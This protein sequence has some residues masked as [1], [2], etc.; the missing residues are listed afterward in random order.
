MI[1]NSVRPM[2]S[3]TENEE[4]ARLRAALEDAEQ[5]LRV[6][7]QGTLET[8]RR[9]TER[10]FFA[11]F[12]ESPEPMALTR[13][14]DGLI[15]DVNQEW[16]LLTRFSRDEVI[17]R[18]T[19]EIN[20]WPTPADRDAAMAPLIAKGRLR[21]HE[22]TMVMKGGAHRLTRMNSS[23]IN[24]MGEPHVLTHVKDITAE[25]MA[26][27][28][29]RSGELALAQA[30]EKLNEQLRLY[31][32]TENLAHVGHGMATTDGKTI[33]WSN[34]LHAI[35][36]T[37][38]GN[39]LTREQ[40]LNSI[41]EEDFERYLQARRKMDGTTVEFRL[42]H[43]DGSLRWM[44]SR[45]HRQLNS[46]GE[47]VEFDLVQDITAERAVM[48]ALQ[49]KLDFIEKITSRIPDVV[50]Q[51][52]LG[53]DGRFW[54]PFI[55]EGL[56]K[57]FRVAPEDARRDPNLLFAAIHPDDAPEVLALM[58]R[59]Y[60]PGGIWTHEYRVR[61]DDGSVRWVQGHASTYSE[62]DGTLVSY[63]S[64]TDINNLKEAEVRA[65]DS[66]AR[67]RS[68]TDLSSDW[69]WELDDQFRFTRIDGFR[70]NKSVISLHESLGKTRWEIGGLNLSDEDWR[71]HRRTL[72]AHQRFQDFEI[73]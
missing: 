42:K 44:R 35:A 59:E 37:T 39:S 17:G 1:A 45:M 26:V 72:E 2:F 60:R 14:R 8:K 13:L 69:Y 24:V 49:E 52:Q 58:R 19:V 71:T 30:N 10:L 20:H 16:L 65:Q 25:R 23:L 51:Y 6:A 53:S 46:A 66:E 54:F 41:Y 67:F 9:Y 36:G 3:E 34:G 57:M 50:L 62:A 43:A 38:P 32:L 4:I 33:T 28:A 11:A 68:L 63:G 47:L 61:L 29:L 21:D 31:E 15:V 56:R 18:T 70:Q 73:Q 22:V 64:V 7:D 40:V 27:E 5:R 48:Q 12:D 55:S